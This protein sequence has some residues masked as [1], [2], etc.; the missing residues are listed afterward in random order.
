MSSME[1]LVEAA[2]GRRPIKVGLWFNVAMKQRCYGRSRLLEHFMADPFYNPVV[3][4]HVPPALVHDFT[5]YDPAEPG[6][7]VFKAFRS[8]HDRVLAE[9]FCTTTKGG[10]W[11]IRKAVPL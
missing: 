6:E 3:P 9:I 4:D 8:L 10:L 11:V 7:A 5:L 1:S 2:A